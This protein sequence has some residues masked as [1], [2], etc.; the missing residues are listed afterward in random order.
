MGSHPLQIADY[1]VAMGVDHEP[2]F[3]W[4][5][6]H[7]LRKCDAIIALVKKCSTRYLKH[8][9][10]FGIECPKTVEDA[11]ELDKHNG[12]TTWA[13]AIAKEM[14]NVQVAFNPLQDIIQPPTGYQFV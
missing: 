13:D 4:W 5:V 12:N 1:S 10:K 11:L 9:H 2:S 7:T 6:P 14:K 8:T 3:N